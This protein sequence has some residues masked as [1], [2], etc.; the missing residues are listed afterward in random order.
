MGWR[1][2]SAAFLLMLLTA[3][4]VIEAYGLNAP[5]TRS[6]DGRS[7]VVRDGDTLRIGD[8]DVR[9]DGID[10]P[11]YAQICKDGTGKDWPC[12][13]IARTALAGLVAGHIIT[14]EARARDEY[15]R[16]VAICRDERGN[17]LAAAM[18]AQ[19]LA[20]S[21]GWFGDGPYGGEANAAKSARRGIWA[22]RFDL[23]AD[24]RASHPRSAAPPL[25]RPPD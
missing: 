13:R 19:G 18:A 5:E 12:G 17:D 3:W 21:P 7:I 1:G 24:W 9:L 11:E 8:T 23:P 14:C 6:A 15:S 16:I 22:G 20:I 4:A 10:A 2:R 25:P